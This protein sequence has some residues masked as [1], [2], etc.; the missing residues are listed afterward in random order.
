MEIRLDSIDIDFAR[1]EIRNARVYDRDSQGSVI[2]LIFHTDRYVSKG[3]AS[4]VKLNKDF[5]SLL[6]NSIIETI[7]T[8]SDEEFETLKEAI[9]A[10]VDAYN[11]TSNYIKMT[12][13][14][15]NS[16]SRYPENCFYVKISQQGFRQGIQERDDI[17]KLV[18]QI[19]HRDMSKE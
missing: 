12:Y 19:K 18:P 14:T 7:T 8:M 17:I 10:K 13:W 2:V 5:L 1:Y 3:I 16:S 6:K 11:N 9:N 4:K 15:D